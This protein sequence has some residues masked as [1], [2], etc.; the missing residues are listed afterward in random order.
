M[1]ARKSWLA[2]IASKPP[3]E[4]DTAPRCTRGGWIRCNARLQ[5]LDA[6]ECVNG[7]TITVREDAMTHHDRTHYTDCWRV[8]PD[9][10]VAEVERLR[11]ALTEVSTLLEGGRHD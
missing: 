5:A 2:F 7:S 3:C 8:H 11:A 4:C 10:A 9:C 1:T 6:W